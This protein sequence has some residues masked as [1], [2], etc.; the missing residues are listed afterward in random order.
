MGLS[1][2]CDLSSAQF[3]MNLSQRRFKCTLDI[4]TS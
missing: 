2:C 3:G 4:N 1:E